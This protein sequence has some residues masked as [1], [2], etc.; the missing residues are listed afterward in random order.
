MSARF[1]QS[2]RVLLFFL[3][4]TVFIPAFGQASLIEISAPSLDRNTDFGFSVSSTPDVDGDGIADV[5]VGDREGQID[6][7]P[8]DAGVA[9]LYS[10]GKQ[11]FLR[12]FSSPIPTGGGEFSFSLDAGG[13]ATN[14]RGVF[15]ALFENIPSATP[16]AGQAY[17]FDLETGELIHTLVSPYAQY[18]GRFGRAVTMIQDL[19]GDEIEEVGVAA[20]WEEIEGS[21][22]DAGFVHIFDGASGSFL[23]SLA[24]PRESSEAWFGFSIKGCPD[25]NGNQSPEIIVS[26]PQ[27]T[28]PGP[29]YMGGLVYIF[30][31][32]TREVIREIHS[33]NEQRDADFGYF[34]DLIP[35]ISGDSLPEIGIAAPYEEDTINHREG[36]VH[37]FNGGTG[38]LFK[39]IYSP[40]PQVHDFIG[41]QFKGF[42]K[43][44]MT[45]EVILAVGASGYE[46]K[47]Y[48]RA[49]RVFLISPTTG[50]MTG[51]LSSPHEINGGGFGWAMD[52]L[53]DFDN[54]NQTEIV[55]SANGETREGIVGKGWTYVFRSRPDLEVQPTFEDFRP[56]LVE[57]GPSYPTIFH[58]INFGLNPINLVCPEVELAGPDTEDFQINSFDWTCTTGASG[59]SLIPG[60][61][62]SIEVVFAPVSPGTKTAFL[63][64]H[65]TD[66]D[67]PT[68]DVPLSGI[69]VSFTPTPTL[70][71]TETSTATP[72]PT[73]TRTSTQPPCVS[74]YYLLDS[75][76]GRHRV[77]NPFL[78]TGP[79]YF[80]EPIARDM[81]RALCDAAGAATPDLVVL[82][83][84]GGVHFVA[85][86][87]CNIL[88]E[89]YFGNVDKNEFP[90]G[91]AVDLEMAADSLGFWVL[92]DY[93]GIYRAG[94]SKEPSDPALVP[95][96]D[97]TGVLGYDVPFGQMRDPELPEPGGASLRAVSLAV[98]D[99]DRDGRAEGYLI[100]DSQ[101]G[102]FHLQPDGTPFL[103]GAFA[104][105]PVNHP[106]R[107]LDPTGYVWPFFKGLDIA[108]DAELFKTQ[109]GLVIL[110]GWDGIHPVP[111]DVETNPVY[112][113]NN[114]ASNADDTPLQ[115]VGLPYVT[116]GFDDPDTPDIESD[117]EAFGFDA[118]SVFADLEF[119]AGCNDG[120]YTLDKFGGIFAFGSARTNEKEPFP[121]FGGSPY[122][123]PFLYAEDIELF[124]GDE[125]GVEGGDGV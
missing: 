90:Q 77:G 2:L 37:I 104:G 8:E 69:G 119:S 80:G 89:F 42:R 123:F 106:L 70:T 64:I 95:D 45:D 63:R 29:I 73:P 40:S 105:F 48:T 91:R 118:E 53:P 20:P 65:S 46:S 67:D 17:V 83:G 26:A 30:D 54:D 57:E 22:R 87:E 11:E 101:G 27:S 15:G 21:R 111:V 3:V 66:I 13:T 36:V 31:L 108:R 38:E 81:E 32:S 125:T 44:P 124:A 102:R 109:E 93:G 6:G 56:R 47:R 121:Q 62:K 110:D 75:F 96:T 103:D 18:R 34:V 84:F 16:S 100:L 71:L 92:T 98:I 43:G 19:N 49:G 50:S 68:L 10:V 115:E 58:A 117:R 33:P 25:L 51:Y 122:F 72:T 85:S 120:L 78:I 55:V 94:S 52:T 86:S 1:C 12:A 99:F 23:F 61:S 113:A 41:F 112:F 79:V 35:D 39:S 82:D 59:I 97:R 14:P 107:L 76:G 4:S 74:G 7:D 24:E 60:A 88:Q 9:R 114:R 116:N 28:R 5:L